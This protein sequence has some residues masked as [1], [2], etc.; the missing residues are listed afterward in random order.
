MMVNDIKDL[1]VKFASMVIGYRVYHLSQINNI[2]GGTIHIA[3]WM[4]K[5]NVDYDLA[6]ALREQLILNLELI[7]KDKRQKF[8]FGQL[9]IGL[10]FYF[11]NFFLIIG[12]IQWSVDT[13]AMLLIKNNIKMLGNDFTKTIWGYF[14]D[15]QKKMHVRERIPEHVVKRYEDSI[16]FMI[17][18]DTCQME[19]VD[20]RNSW[21]MSMGYEVGEDMLTVYVDHFLSK[22]VDPNV[23]RFGTF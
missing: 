7:K 15:F 21:V 4:L 11:Q 5:E 22:P 17:D 19:V 18:T 23:L 1:E 6:E 8:K 12:D 16:Y 14:K 13:S 9:I 3:Y 20:P 10:F 2:L